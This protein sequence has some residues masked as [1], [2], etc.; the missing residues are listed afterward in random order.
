[1]EGE[2]PE[3]GID[4]SLSGDRVTSRREEFSDTS[5]VEASFGET[6]SSPQSST[7]GAN[8]N[9]IILVVDDRIFVRNIWLHN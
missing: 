2:K 6:E 9:R 7:A 5:S 1:L 3:G 4:S 8:N